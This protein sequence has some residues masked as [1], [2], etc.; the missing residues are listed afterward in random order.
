MILTDLQKSFETINHIIILKK[1]SS[2]GFSNQLIGLFGSYFSN[3]AF[4]ANIKNKVSVVAYIKCGI[5]QRSIFGLLLFLIFIIDMFQ[6]VDC[7]LIPLCRQ[8]F[9][10]VPT[11]GMPKK[12][13]KYSRKFFQMFVSGL[14]IKNSA[15]ILGKTW[16]KIYG[17][18]QKGN[19]RKQ[20]R[21]ETQRNTH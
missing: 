10:S 2:V 20:S 12:L 17:F 21:Y 9:F 4:Q 15:L 6:A 19:K 5:P 3:R 14:P 13:S 11:Q 7:W 8:H 1:M 16:P 18:I